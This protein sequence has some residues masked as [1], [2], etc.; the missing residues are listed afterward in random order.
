MI[1]GAL[2]KV[3]A[4]VGVVSFGCSA[5]GILAGWVACA[6]IVYLIGGIPFSLWAALWPMAVLPGRL[7]VE[8]TGVGRSV[9]A[10]RLVRASLVYSNV[11][12]GG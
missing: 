1:C 5:V 7:A 4:R 2:I 9:W 11:S 6:G 12:V 10:I 3:G 8:P